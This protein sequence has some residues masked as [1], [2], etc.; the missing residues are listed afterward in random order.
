MSQH[1]LYGIRIDNAS[2]LLI[3]RVGKA[4]DEWEEAHR[5]YNRN[6]KKKVSFKRETIAGVRSAFC[7]LKKIN[8]ER[9][10]KSIKR[11]NAR[12]FDKI[13]WT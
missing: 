4:A 5:E 10:M 6:A 9:K 3:L 7:H 13:T 1:S 2:N 8:H 11:V 12:N